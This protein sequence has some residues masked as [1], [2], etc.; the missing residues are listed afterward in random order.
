MTALAFF[1]C[2]TK[3]EE[4]QKIKEHVKQVNE[5][6]E[7]KKQKTISSFE[8]VDIQLAKQKLYKERIDVMRAFKKKQRENGESPT[9]LT[10]K[11]KQQI[12]AMEEFKD[13]TPIQ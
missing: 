11:S 1:S 9:R 5:L 10:E 7:E 6:K 3:Q 4:T 2:E 13:L 8:Q 12:N